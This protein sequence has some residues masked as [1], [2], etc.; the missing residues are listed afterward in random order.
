[1]PHIDPWEADRGRLIDAL[2]LCGAAFIPIK[3]D[4]FGEGPHFPAWQDLW[5]EALEDFKSFCKRSV[6]RK[7]QLRFS[8]GEDLL[9][10]R[11][12]E[13]KA[14]TPD[15]R[16]NFGV[17]HDA[18]SEGREGWRTLEWL[19]DFWGRLYLCEDCV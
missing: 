16:Y 5:R 4:V 19:P 8:K 9:R 6:V 10:T 13:S 12:G 7:R 1:M 17:G 3:K 2:R 14:H 11:V 15:V 18:A